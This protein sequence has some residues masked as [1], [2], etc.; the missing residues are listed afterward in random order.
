MGR[1]VMIATGGTGGHVYPAVALAQKIQDEWP[2]AEV[3]FVGGGLDS[4]RYFD[5]GVFPWRSVSCGT[6]FGLS[7]IRM[8]KSCFK[9]ACGVGQSCKII[10]DFRPD[11]VVGFGSYY[12]FPPLVAAKM[13]SVPFLLHEANTIPGKVTKALSNWAA[14]TGVHFPRTSSYLKGSSVEVGMPLRRGY[15]KDSCVD[16]HAAGYFGLSDD[17]LTLLVFGGSQGAKVI[18]DGVMK[19]FAEMKRLDELQVVHIAGDEAEAA[20]LREQY[21]KLNLRACVKAYE[22]NMQH[23]WQIADVVVCRS[24]AGAV[25]ELLEFEVPAILIPFARAADDHQTFNA[26]F[27]VDTVG[28][29]VKVDE[30]DIASGGIRKALERFLDEDGKALNEKKHSMNEYKRQSRTRDMFSLVAEQLGK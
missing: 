21:G 7:P 6:F 18:N 3:L 30:R 25:A 8:I 22:T 29:G 5:R 23:A 14:V 12:C 9:I 11:V 1:K 17:L 20:K 26:D 15:S 24:G 16:K 2:D 28:G 4:N 13:M 19:A 10:R 27:I